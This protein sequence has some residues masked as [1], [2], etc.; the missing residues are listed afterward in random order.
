MFRGIKAPSAV[1]VHG[2]MLRNGRPFYPS[3]YRGAD[4]VGADG[5]APQSGERSQSAA[6]LTATSGVRA[7]RYAAVRNCMARYISPILVDSVLGRA[8]RTRGVTARTMSDEAIEGIVEES[9]IGLRLFVEPSR[10]SGL[11]IELA[12][13]LGRRVE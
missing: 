6:E 4:H 9:M 10:L 1:A 12:E 5:R 11:M 7:F 13:I 3:R 8:M 2:S